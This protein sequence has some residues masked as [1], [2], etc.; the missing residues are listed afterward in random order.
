VT[1][2][3][4]FHGSDGA[5]HAD[6]KRLQLKQALSAA[7][8]GTMLSVSEDA[9][10]LMAHRLWEM[11]GRGDGFSEVDWTLAGRY[12]EFHRRYTRVA[13]YSIIEPKPRHLNDSRGSACRVCKRSAPEARFS[14][15]AHAVPHLLGNKSLLVR[16]ECDDCNASFGK[17]YENAV[18][19][20]TNP[21]RTLTRIEGKEN[22]IPRYKTPS[23]RTKIEA[24]KSGVQIA[25]GPGEVDLLKRDDD[26]NQFVLHA[27]TSR[28]VPIHAFKSLVRIA[29]MVMPEE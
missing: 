23:Q 27:P 15:R 12:L 21:W 9:V 11:R 16:Y 4:H 14:T 6:G 13:S 22:S 3:L 19:I 28:Y 20:F 18:G 1:P 25:L 5:R 8:I 24:T 29:L 7:K 17:R 10:R 2:H 26:K